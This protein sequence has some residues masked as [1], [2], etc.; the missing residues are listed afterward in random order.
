MGK[1]SHRAIIHFWPAHRQF[2][3]QPAQ[4]QGRIAQSGARPNLILPRNLA[5]AMAPPFAPRGTAKGM[6]AL[7][8]FHNAWRCGTQF[9]V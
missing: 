4:G 9:S 6:F 7:R 2:S 1:V 5:R 3:H 8:P